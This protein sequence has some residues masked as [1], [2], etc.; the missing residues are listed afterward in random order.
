M[1]KLIVLLILMHI[2][3]ACQSDI[4]RDEN[5]IIKCGDDV[6]IGFI[7]EVDGVSYKVIDS[8]MLYLSLIHI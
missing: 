5:G 6:S 3:T 4:Y 8:T 2:T 1:K 7:G